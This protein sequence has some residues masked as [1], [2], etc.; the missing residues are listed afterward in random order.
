[1]GRPRR[2]APIIPD[3]QARAAPKGAAVSQ[4]PGLDDAGAGL[5]PPIL[6][7]GETQLGA[8]TRGRRCTPLGGRGRP[9]VAARG[10]QVELGARGPRGSWS[11]PGRGSAGGRRGGAT[12]IVRSGRFGVGSGV[13]SGADGS[14]EV[15]TGV[16]PTSSDRFVTTSSRTSAAAT[17]DS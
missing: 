15:G 7:S 16:G 12:S 14:G 11:S 6:L 13:G 9:L 8:L 5:F 4:V 1:M 3:G 10:G 2:E 17:F